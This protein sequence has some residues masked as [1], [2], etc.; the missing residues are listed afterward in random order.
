MAVT[1]ITPVKM[2]S[3]GALS[4]AITLTAATSA[5]DGFV[6][7]FADKDW[8]TVLIV[9]N[10]NA[11]A[12]KTVTVKK[13]DSYQ[14]VADNTLSVA[15]NTLAVL[16]I[17]SAPHKFTAGDNKGKVQVIPESTDIKIAAVVLP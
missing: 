14:A 16:V 11:D 4:D 8:K 7:P 2:A 10:A 9:Q 12:A 17:E 3:T 13:G 1:A 15:K 6:I 5:A